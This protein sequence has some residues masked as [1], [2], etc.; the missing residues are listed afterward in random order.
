[1]IIALIDTMDPNINPRLLNGNLGLFINNENATTRS[2]S[3]FTQLWE[4]G[5]LINPVIGMRFNPLNPKLTVGALDPADYEGEINWV[6]LETPEESSSFLNIFKMDGFKG[7]NGSFFPYGSSDT[8]AT[9]DSSKY[10][11]YL[12]TELPSNIVHTTIVFNNIAVPDT[13]PYLSNVGFMGPLQ[14]PISHFPSGRLDYVVEC[15]GTALPY[16]SLTAVINGVDY[17]ID[18]KDNLLHPGA[19]L[20]ADGLCPVGFQNNTIEG[21]DQPAIALGLAFLRSVYV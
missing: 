18:S 13:T 17:Q 7:Y 21:S 15:N 2:H 16:I 1:M 3:Y 5:K 8:R 14:G 11:H 12:Y 20:D 10:R 9:L 6:P 4:S 19:L